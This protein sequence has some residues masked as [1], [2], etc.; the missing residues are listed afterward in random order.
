MVIHATQ[1]DRMWFRAHP[2]REYRLRRQTLA[3]VQHWAFQPGP[4]YA[5]WCIIRRADGVMEAFALRVG[6]TCDDHDL[7]LEQ[8][9]DHLRDAA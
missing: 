1:I 9:F 2:D 7:E 4:G 3:E 8:F 5:P 6:E